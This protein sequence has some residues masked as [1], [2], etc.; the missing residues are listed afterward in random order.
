[1]ENKNWKAQL[2]QKPGMFGYDLYIFYKAPNGKIGYVVSG[3]IIKE[4]ERGDSIDIPP[5]LHIEGEE[6]AK[7]I[8]EVFSNQ[9]IKIDKGHT[10]GKLEATEK[11]LED[12]R[13]LVFEEPK[14]INV[15]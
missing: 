14:V 9:G 5:T 13:R 11:H 8:L 7:A 1:M 12:M 4:I 10:E 3:N 15:E 6:M 2:V